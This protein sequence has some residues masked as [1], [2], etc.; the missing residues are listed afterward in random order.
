M[1]GKMPTALLTAR[2]DVHGNRPGEE[3][4][5]SLQRRRAGSWKKRVVTLHG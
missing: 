2:G 3:L 4:R 5:L 1:H